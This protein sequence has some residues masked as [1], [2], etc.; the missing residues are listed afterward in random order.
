MSIPEFPPNSEAS[1]RRAQQ[2][3]EKDI[4]R[5]TSEEP[6]RRPKSLGRQF[7]ETFV[8][9][10]AKSAGR[11]V[12]FDVLLPQAKET[13]AESAEQYVRKLMFGVSHRFR[14]GSTPP[15]SGSTGYV[16][17]QGV[18]MR[19][20]QSSSQRAL[21][22]Q[23]R[24]RFDFDE[25]I[26]NNRLEAEQVIDGLFEVVSR[27]G[28]ASVADLYGLVGIKS[29]YTDNNWGWTNLRGAGVARIRGG[30]LLDLPEPEPIG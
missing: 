14:S 30:Y 27:Y 21:S 17:Y 7:K 20:T 25:I 10:D 2:E 29:T 24:S 26:L 28:Q 11:F 15:Q 18:S 5:I 1:K 19:N 22:R 12:L 16:N 23:A 9:G 8:S 6:K 3:E 13:I 4:K